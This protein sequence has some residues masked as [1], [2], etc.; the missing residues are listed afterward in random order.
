MQG[1][2]QFDSNLKAFHYHHVTGPASLHLYIQFGASQEAA[3]FSLL[4]GRHTVNDLDTST[5]LSEVLARVDRANK[6]NGW[7]LRVKQAWCRADD[8]PSKG[9]C[10]YIAYKLAQEAG[11]PLPTQ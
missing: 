4:P 2:I 6:E 9:Q 1:K 7:L 3:T 11:K 10:A 5:L 8:Y